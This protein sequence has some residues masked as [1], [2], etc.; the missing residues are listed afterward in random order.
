MRTRRGV[1]GV[2]RGVVAAPGF[3]AGLELDRAHD[4]PIV[5]PCVD[6][7]AIAGNDR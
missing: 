4:L 3:L 1:D 5:F 2:G 6:D 7:D